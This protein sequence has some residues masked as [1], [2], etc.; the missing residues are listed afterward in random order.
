MEK[1]KPDYK[2]IY[3]DLIEKKFPEKKKDYDYFFKKEFVSALDIIHLNQKIFKSSNSLDENGNQLHK[4]YDEE[5]IFQILSYQKKNKL[6]N[7]QLANHFNLSRNTITK[8][9]KIFLM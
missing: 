1:L 5:T 7:S 8:W 2:K 6:N 3:L 9:K 4:S